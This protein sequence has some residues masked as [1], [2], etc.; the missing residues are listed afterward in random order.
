M[1]LGGGRLSGWV[2]RDWVVVAV[3]LKRP[4]RRSGPAS[5]RVHPW[6][7]SLCWEGGRTT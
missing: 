3:A 5:L 4:A 2:R 1:M 6:F 7:N